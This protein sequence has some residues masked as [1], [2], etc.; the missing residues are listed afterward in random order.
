MYVYIYTIL[1]PQFDLGLLS[2]PHCVEDNEE[3]LLG[4][5]S[6]AVTRI[7]VSLGAWR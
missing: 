6:G 7:K 3:L 1:D 2:R 5:S 4:S